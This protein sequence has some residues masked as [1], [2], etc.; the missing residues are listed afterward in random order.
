MK[1]ELDSSD[2]GTSAKIDEQKIID[3]TQKLV[4]TAKSQLQEDDLLYE[5]IK[6]TRCD[7]T[8]AKSIFDKMKDLGLGV[9]TNWMMPGYSI[10]MF[11]EMRGYAAEELE[12]LDRKSQE[13][14]EEMERREPKFLE[15]YGND[16]SKWSEDVWDEYDY[17]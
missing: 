1:L 10:G 6:L 15:K 7:L 8:T 11:A 5:I 17:G 2:T 12:Q 9:C 4:L 14:E 3:I 16:R 13:V